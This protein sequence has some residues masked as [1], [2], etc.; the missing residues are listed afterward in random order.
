[1]NG[2]ILLILKQK[3]SN[4][5]IS[6][7]KAKNIANL[8]LVQEKLTEIIK[9]V[10]ELLK[11]KKAEAIPS[12]EYN[13][14]Y[15]ELSKKVRELEEEEKKLST[16]NSNECI[17]KEQLKEINRIL[18]DETVDLLDSQIMRTLLN[19]IKVIDKHN[20]EFQFNCNLNIIEK[21]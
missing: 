1:M 10:L 5:K 4:V 20:V 8:T 16:G 12:D 6:I 11:D 13:K 2:F 14:K 3:Y 19:Y 7:L 18:S 15:D 17:R 21:I 9:Q